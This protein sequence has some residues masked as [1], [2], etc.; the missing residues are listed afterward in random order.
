MSATAA[1]V[2]PS[3]H[4]EVLLA[5]QP[6]F[7]A[8]LKV[9]GY[10]L[11]YRSIGQDSA[12]FD[13]ADVASAE[14][15]TS[16]FMDIGLNRIVE[17]KLAYINVSQEFLTSREP[18]A[19]PVDRVALEFPGEGPF[20]DEFLSLLDEY[21]AD[22]FRLVADCLSVTPETLSVIKRVDAVKIDVLAL[23]LDEAVRQVELLQPLKCEIIATRVESEE[24][25]SALEKLGV[26]YLQGFFFAKPRIVSGTR[27]SSNK[28]TTLRLL[29]SLYD[30]ETQVAEISDLVGQDAGLSYKLMRFINSAALSLPGKVD[31]IRRAVV[32]MGLAALKRWASLIVVAS[33]DDKPSELTRT[34][35]VRA[36]LCERLCTENGH[37]DP[38]AAFTVGLFSGLDALLDQPLAEAIAE[39][40]LAPELTQALLEGEVVLAEALACALAYERGEWM[41]LKF[42][43]LS[44]PTIGA[45][46]EESLEWASEAMQGI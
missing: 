21:R 34:L 33:V 38:G 13:D 7:D 5:R 1:T 41:D 8:D 44:A 10:E 11:L 37:E 14:V 29:A 46:Y 24:E 22:G 3:A 40:P 26:H 31:S 23:G 42:A 28:L 18:K 45:L 27:V 4:A 16:S 19:L 6:I 2:S 36:R 9:H 17:N 43:Q 25:S 20:D 12:A 32:F 35:L 39:L 15:I 30:P